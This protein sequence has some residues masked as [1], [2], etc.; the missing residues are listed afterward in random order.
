MEMSSFE[1]SQQQVYIFPRTQYEYKLKKTSVFDRILIS[2]FIQIS[3]QI[4][5]MENLDFEVVYKQIK[6]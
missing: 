4:S 6:K 3:N 1:D 2:H 5:W